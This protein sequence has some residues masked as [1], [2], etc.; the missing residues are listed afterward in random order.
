MLRLFHVS[1]E[2]SIRTFHPR[3]S[4]AWSSLPENVVWAVDEP[5]L[6]NYLLPR[7]CPR[8]TYRVSP[9][10]SADDR[11]RFFVGRTSHVVAIGADWLTR[12]SKQILFVYELPVHSF[13]LLDASAGYWISRA[14]VEPTGVTEVRQ[15]LAALIN[16]EVELRVVPQ[17]QELREAVLR[18]TVDFSIIRMRRLE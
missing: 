18:S 10:T 17:L 13:H 12:A 4:P 9:A 3:P 2:P 8:V 14:A 1:E 15:P 6:P 11:A 7:D 5:H 16:R